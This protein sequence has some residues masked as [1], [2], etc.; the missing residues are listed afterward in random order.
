MV[1]PGSGSCFVAMN[2]KTWNKIPPEDQKI[3]EGLSPWVVQQ[4]IKGMRGV[5]G[6]TQKLFRDKGVE[7]IDLSPEETARWKKVSK[8]VRDEWVKEVEAKGLPSKAVMDEITNI[9][10]GI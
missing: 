1:D 8:P 6:Y 5:L 3:I 7:A 4:H 10:S 2:M 9:M